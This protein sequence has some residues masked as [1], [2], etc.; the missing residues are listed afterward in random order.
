MRS[1]SQRSQRVL[2]RSLA[3][4]KVKFHWTLLILYW[5]TVH[6]IDLDN[7]RWK[8][9]GADKDFREWSMEWTSQVHFLYCS[10]LAIFLALFLGK[11]IWLTEPNEQCLSLLIASMVAGFGF[12]HHIRYQL[13]DHSQIDP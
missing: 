8:R 3:F 4:G 10:S 6:E 13:V 5:P 7:K 12:L 2:S 9:R 11:K 1:M